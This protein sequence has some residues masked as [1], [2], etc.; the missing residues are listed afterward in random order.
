MARAGKIDARGIAAH[1]RKQIMQARAETATTG[2][3]SHESSLNAVKKVRVSRQDPTIKS[4]LEII[5]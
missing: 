2:N 1:A 4:I 5:N 3:R